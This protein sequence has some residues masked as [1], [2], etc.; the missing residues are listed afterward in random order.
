MSPGVRIIHLLPN[1]T[2][3]GLTN[4]YPFYPGLPTEA[5]GFGSE[6]R[7]DSATFR[8]GGDETNTAT[9]FPLGTD[10][11]GV[12]KFNIPVAAFV[13]TPVILSPRVGNPDASPDRECGALTRRRYRGCRVL[14]L[15][16]RA[17]LEGYFKPSG[18]ATS[19]R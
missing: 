8:L 19:T 15:G 5:T 16:G 11:G 6:S 17:Y 1:A 18:M 12:R 14:S 13:R 4:I 9:P 10:M 7:R 3:L 2:L